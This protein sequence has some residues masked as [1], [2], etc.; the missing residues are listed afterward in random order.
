MFE[1]RKE[2]YEF[3]TLVLS[4]LGI[5]AQELFLFSSRLFFSDLSGRFFYR[6]LKLT[7]PVIYKLCKRFKPDIV[8][9]LGEPDLDFMLNTC[10]EYRVSIRAQQKHLWSVLKQNYK[11][12]IQVCN[13]IEDNRQLIFIDTDT[14]NPFYEEIFEFLKDYFESYHIPAGNCFIDGYGVLHI[15]I[16]VQGRKNNSLSPSELAEILQLRLINALNHSSWLINIPY[17]YWSVDTVYFPDIERNLK[18]NT[19]VALI[20]LSKSGREYIRKTHEQEKNPLAET[21]DETL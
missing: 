1:K 20:A 6:L 2:F 10:S 5:L 3:V 11:R 4:S 12:F 16:L 13:E 14:S 9:Y 7:Y 19:L 15:I 8:Q 18:N 17:G 21:L